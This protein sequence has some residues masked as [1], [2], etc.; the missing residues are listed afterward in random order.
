MAYL[1]QVIL[2]KAF[3]RLVA[4]FDFDALALKRRMKLLQ[5]LHAVFHFL[6]L[7]GA[8]FKASWLDSYQKV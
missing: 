3:L 4:C 5:L 6:V 2:S 1:V 8:L 7:V